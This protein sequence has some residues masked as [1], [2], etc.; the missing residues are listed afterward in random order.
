MT[1]VNRGLGKVFVE[2]LCADGARRVYASARDVSKLE[3]LVQ[4]Y[5]DQVI[6]I[7]LDVANH[8]QVLEAAQE[9]GDVDLLI[10]NAGALAD[11]GPI[12][13]ADLDA[14][15]ELF[16]VNF[17]G[18]VACCRA[19]APILKANGGGTIVNILSNLA[20]VSIPYQ[21][22]YCASK[23]AGWSVTHAIRA[24]LEPQG[25]LVVACLPDAFETDMVAYIDG[26]KMSPVVIARACIDAVANEQEDLFGPAVGDP[27]GWSVRFRTEPKEVEREGAKISAAHV[28]RKQRKRAR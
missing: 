19:F 18:M 5:P 14:G 25:T 12:S 24:E 27:L 28:R 26:T 4:R 20:L 6:P 22:F 10:N 7:A 11:A 17:W 15:R 9:C 2:E 1:G 8:A 13:A 16:E 3:P 23:A 21:G